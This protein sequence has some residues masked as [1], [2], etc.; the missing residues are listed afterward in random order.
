MPKFKS[1]LIQNV[2]LYLILAVGL[3]LFANY[4]YNQVL[5]FWIAAATTGGY[6]LWGIAHHYLENRLDWK[7][8]SEYLLMGCVVLII[9]KLVLG[10]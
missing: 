1:H 7:V 10:T 4:R 5:Q 9:F 3:L 2:V 8:A 6:V